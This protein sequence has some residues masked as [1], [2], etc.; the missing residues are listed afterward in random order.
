M[1]DSPPPASAPVRGWERL[2]AIGLGVVVVVVAVVLGVAP[3]RDVATADGAT[4]EQYDLQ[5]LLDRWAAAVRAADGDALTSI[6]DPVTGAALLRAERDRATALTAV[7]TDEFAYVLGPA[8]DVPPHLADRYDGAPVRIHTVELRYAL[9]GVDDAPT[10]GRATVLFVRRSDG[11]YIA[12]DDPL[13]DDAATW[14]GPWDHGPVDVLDV[15]TA[16][17]RAL[18]L[19]HPDRQD[20]ATVVA[21]ELPAAVDAVSQLWGDEWTRR[22]AVVVTSTRDEFTALVGPRHDGDDIAAVSISDAVAPGA[23]HATGQRIVFSPSAGD[24]LTAS[25]LRD[26]LRHEMT[27]IATRAHTVDGA[28]MWI[29]EGYAD[30]IGYRSGTAGDVSPSDLRRIAPGL[31]AEIERTGAPDAPPTD[32][33]FADPRRSRT[34]YEAAWSLAAFVAD[35]AGEDA[36]TDL[37]RQLAAAPGDTARTDAVVDAVL[38]ITTGELVARWADWLHGLI[39]TV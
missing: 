37:Y 32:T 9:T 24:R 7:P 18:V 27:H 4:T 23:A 16:G 20:F 34:A 8:L 25:G 21:A 36:L 29:L 6:V 17:G 5:A 39:T 15:P 10:T 28:P 13:P 33:D 12:D 30:Y 3:D 14:R 1:P 22:T 11:W 19:T 35:D 2:A 31:V 38:G 26:V